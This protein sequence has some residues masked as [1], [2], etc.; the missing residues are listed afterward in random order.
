MWCF[1]RFGKSETSLPDG[2]V[3]HIGG[4]HEDFY[5]PDFFIYNDVTTIGGDG[6]IAIR[7]YPT[8]VFP[9]TDF[10]TATTADNSII[11]IG[12]LGYPEH[13]LVGSTPVFR[14]AI[15]TMGIDRVDTIGEG[16]GWIHK[17]SAVLADDASAIVVRG[18]VIWRGDAL[19]MIEN[20][21]SW[22]LDIGTGRWTRLTAL[23]WQRW[24]M[25]RVD[26]KPNRLWDVRQELWRRD[27]GWTGQDSYWK[28]D[29]AP[30]FD[31]LAALYRPDEDSPIPRDGSEYNVFHTVI[32]GL[33]VR[34]TEDR[35]HVQA[36]VKGRLSEDR[37]KTLQ[38]TL[39]SAL[40]RLDASQW[41]IE[42]Q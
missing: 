23:D 30:D 8:S 27:H 2:R 33:E 12:N 24:T 26:R 13:R 1:D 14:V 21:D 31:A 29:D 39:L 16:P 32:D 22:S 36:V 42:G 19:S 18:G 28:F 41:E 38:R 20:I 6:G 17:H 35:F 3:V 9:P 4:E 7:G 25:L 15:D 40:E 5:D 11:V 34:F 37:L 10:H